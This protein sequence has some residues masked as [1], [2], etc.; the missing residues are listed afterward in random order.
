MQHTDHQFECECGRLQGSLSNAPRLIHLRC[1]CHDCQTYAHALSASNRVLDKQGGTEVVTTLQQHVRF[2]RGE[3]NLACLSLSGQGML[4]WYA[5]CCNT[6]IAN[7]ARDAK[8]SFVSLLHT[9]LGASGAALERQL[10]TRPVTVNPKHAKGKVDY[11]PAAALW[12]TSAIIASVMRARLNGSWKSSPFFRAD[13]GAPVA[14]PRVLDAEERE[15]AAKSADIWQ[16][17]A[18]LRA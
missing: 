15:L 9:A 17:P 2:T 8:L 7:T 1:H 10:G 13:N 14:T 6:P 12:S 3:E 16:A 18:G 11:K 5:S 4:R